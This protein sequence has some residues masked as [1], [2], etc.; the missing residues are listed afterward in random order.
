MNQQPKEI[1]ELGELFEQV[2]L[3]AILDDGK[4][5]V[6]CIP[7]LPL[8]EIQNKYEQIKDQAYFDLKSFVLEN[9][10]M[11]PLFG[12]DYKSNLNLS[13]AENIRNLWPMLTRD[14]TYEISSLINLP[15][16]YIVPGGRF[17]EIYYWDSYFTML[18]LKEDGKIDLIED[19]VSNFAYLINKLGHIPNGNRQYYISRSQPPFFALMVQLLADTK[20][21]DG[22]YL[23]YQKELEKEYAFWMDGAADLKK[24]TSVNRIA[25]MPDGT[26]LNHY[27]DSRAKPREESFSEDV[28]ISKTCIDPAETVFTNLRAGAE[29]GW[30]FSTRWFADNKSISTIETTQIIPVDLNCL[31]YMLEQIIAKTATI[32]GDATKASEFIELSAKRRMAI[33][34]YCWNNQIHFFCDYHFVKQQTLN[35]RTA[36]GLYPLFVSICTQ[37]QANCVAHV[38][39]E[40]LLK[41][42]GL[43]TTTIY[44]GQQW[45][46]PN[47]WAPLQWIAF[48]GLKKY[49][50]QHLANEIG[51]RWI[52][53][54]ET[55]FSKTGK[56]MEKYNVEDLSKLAGGGEYEGQ[57]GFG[58][59]NGVYLALKNAINENI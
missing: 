12:S 21:D 45:D 40:S 6:D 53:L 11:P 24:G 47:G 27:F 25:C 55:V 41:P 7:L 38:V 19:M 46:A 31:M 13:V 16:R 39:E 57:D 36:A 23:K 22:I 59:T 26:I 37:H 29:S 2:Q 14:A 44:S 18:G 33:L 1:F 32:A 3:T 51:T 52:K 20:K 58:W 35:K 42:G 30:D 10:S 50:H 48:T 8:N 5:F 17:R 9:F 28:H 34:E 54:N 15:N 43:V 49:G 4:T 56:L